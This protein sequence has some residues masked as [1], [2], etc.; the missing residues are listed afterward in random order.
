[1]LLQTVAKSLWALPGEVVEVLGVPKTGGPSPI[2][3]SL[4]GT[5]F[6]AVLAVELGEPAPVPQDGGIF[7]HQ[8]RLGEEPLVIPDHNVPLKLVQEE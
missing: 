3:L 6:L 4:L 2:Q 8:Q 5:E 7:L 1:M